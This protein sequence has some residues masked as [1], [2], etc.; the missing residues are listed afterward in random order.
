MDLFQTMASLIYLYLFFLYLHK[1]N[2]DHSIP[3]HSQDAIMHVLVDI[4]KENKN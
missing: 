3:N 2:K 1:G 4:Y